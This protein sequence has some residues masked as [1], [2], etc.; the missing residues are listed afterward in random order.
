MACF[1]PYTREVGLR[2]VGFFSS[3]RRAPSAAVGR[4]P[5]F[6][7]LVG[8]DCQRTVFETRGEAIG[9]SSSFS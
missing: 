9:R 7:I 5:L 8:S 2:V 1:L 4:D 3:Y 6:L